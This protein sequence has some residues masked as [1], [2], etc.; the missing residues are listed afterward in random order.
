MDTL[1]SH[2]GHDEAFPIVLIP[3]HTAQ[4]VPLVFARFD[5]KKAVP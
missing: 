3:P 2:C 4:S 1:K 5:A